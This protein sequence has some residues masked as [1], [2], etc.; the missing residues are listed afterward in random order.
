MRFSEPAPKR[1]GV[2]G[3]YFHSPRG[4]PVSPRSG[5]GSSGNSKSPSKSPAA[6]KAWQKRG[7]AASASRGR[8][9]AD[10]ATASR[11]RWGHGARKPR[12]A[13][14]DDESVDIPRLDGPRE[15]W[16]IAQH[17]LSLCQWSGF[18]WAQCELCEKWRKPSVSGVDL[19]VNENDRFVCSDM[20]AA[21]PQGCETPED[22]SWTRM[23]AFLGESVHLDE[24][25][26]LENGYVENALTFMAFKAE[27]AGMFKGKDGAA[28]K[29]V[30][31][32]GTDAYRDVQHVKA[33]LAQLES[34]IK[35]NYKPS[36]EI[37]EW[38]SQLAL[39][40]SAVEVYRQGWQVCV[41]V[42]HTVCLCVYHSVCGSGRPWPKSTQ[43]VNPIVI[44]HRRHTRMLTFF[45]FSWKNS[46]TGPRH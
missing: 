34:K 10:G 32:V 25:E 36:D 45:F 2:G 12:I 16:S 42:Y 33:L 13:S 38:R 31:S 20:G 41:C 21:C 24:E 3:A 17:D 35:E 14:D 11:G 18:G 7:N 40:S 9:S 30:D 27:D 19:D 43:L 15:K 28:Q 46:S 6:Q 26:T 4:G 39:A 29:F 5:S 1:G 22:K 44:L 23:S 37:Q 8:R